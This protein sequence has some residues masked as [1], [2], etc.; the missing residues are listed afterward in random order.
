MIVLAID[1]IRSNLLLYQQILNSIEGA[2]CVPFVSSSE[3]LAWAHHFD[4]D[5]VLLDYDMPV[6]NGLDFVERFRS[7]P[8]KELTP[9]LMITGAREWNVRRDA[10]KL[11]VNDFLTNPAD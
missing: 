11:G 4:P 6:L 8:G 7:L 2:E 5:V 1:D 9:I 3:A 10:Y